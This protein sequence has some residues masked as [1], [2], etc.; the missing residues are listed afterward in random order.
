MKSKLL[1]LVGCL[2]FISVSAQDKNYINKYTSQKMQYGFI[3][4]K[5]QIYDQNYKANPD[6]K[7]L[8]SM[9]N[10]LNIQ[11]KANGFSY[12]TY[13]TEVKERTIE[14][15]FYKIRQKNVPQKDITYYFHRVD[16]ELLGANTNPKII[17]EE[18]SA[19]YM[20]YY[21]AVTPESGAT[22]VRTYRKVT[23]KDIYPNIDMVFEIKEDK[24]KHVEYTFILRPGADAKQI[25]LHYI[26]ANQTKLVNNKINIDV[27]HG[28]FTESIPASWIKETNN[29]L[30]ITYRVLEKDIYC[31][32]TPF[33]NPT[34]T[35]IIDPNPNLEWGTYYGGGGNEEGMSIFGDAD[36]N[37]FVTGYTM[38][39]NGI[40]TTGSHQETYSTADW[41]A[42][43]AK[44]NTNGVRQWGTYY[45]GETG[46][47]IGRRISCDTDGNI[48][49]TG[50]T[51]STTGIAT[52]GAH[53]ETYAGG[54]VYGIAGDAF[55]VKFNTNGIRQWG[56][57]YGGDGDDCGLG[58]SCDE[59]G[60]VFI[61][62]LTS[63]AA[64]IATSGAYQEVYAG[65]IAGSL[66]GDVFVVKFNTNGVCQWGTYYGG[67]GLDIG[68]GI[69]YDGNG[70]VFVTGNTNSTTGI[71]TSGAY[72]ET[73]AGGSGGSY[74]ADAFIAKFNTDG[75][76]QWGTYYG[77]S[78]CDVGLGIS[79][80]TTG[81]VFV[82]G[83]TASENGIVTSGAH[84]DT[85]AGGSY[86]GCD[87]FVA[88]F[89]TNGVCQWGTY[90]GGS[91]DDQGNGVCYDGDGNIFV[92]G[93]TG[94]ETGIATS[95][96]HQEINAGSDD[97]FIVKFNSDGVRQWGTYYGGSSGDYGVGIFY[98]AGDDILFV[99]GHTRSSTG[100]ATDGAHQETLEMGDDAFVAKFSI[101]EI[102]P[103]NASTILGDTIVC[104]GENSVIYTIPPI[105]NA[106][107]YVWMLP[108]G[109]TGT[110]DTNSIIVNYGEF[111]I[112]GNITV[113]G[114][115]ACGD[116]AESSLAITVNPLPVSAGTILGDTIICQGENSVIYTVSPIDNATSYVWMLPSG[117]TGTSDTNSI[118]V[119][120]GEFAISGNITVKG[121]NACGDGAESSLA[122]TVNP[123]P[124]SAGT[125]LGDTII[126]QGENS[127]IY[128][129]SPIDNATSYVWML[130][131]GVTGTSITDSITVDY[132][133]SA[134]SGN[135]TVM[136]TNVC[137]DGAV[138][139]LPITVNIK[140]PTPTIT[141]NGNILTSDAPEG[142]QWY[143]QG[144]L[145]NG[146]T[147]QDYYVSIDGDYYVIVTLNICSSDPSDTIAVKG[148]GTKGNIKAY[149][150]PV[151]DEL[152]IEIDNNNEI[153]NFDIINSRGNII[154]K[155]N[156]VDKVIVDISNFASGIYFIKLENG[157][158]FESKKIMIK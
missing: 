108:S 154:F 14:D 49:V 128:T 78:K 157:E 130:P 47:S 124:V 43:V 143:N 2:A 66:E 71:A 133:V 90:Y 21:N 153:I 112:S 156:L 60:Y 111:A 63:S 95:G 138:S 18:P 25:K 62:G 158:I 50:F 99:F 140:P 5:G 151:S 52:S 73:Y 33:Y 86:H 155:G 115:N 55:V 8:L 67:N 88:K 105:D 127:V 35:L 121:T 45:G 11:L 24:K 117:V 59:N 22:F 85:F 146:A 87:A 134:I 122:I 39:K 116:G 36:G 114:T 129:V 20:N 27:A 101:C 41:D 42:F 81:N 68:E 104:Q 79:C 76:Y 125:I 92:I 84:Q 120:Y 100:I 102:Y 123:L 32:E 89:N 91:M 69:S 9:H 40:A 107:S 28:S 6:V 77:G 83:Y 37:V 103:A 132:G 26:G 148:I 29:K 119:N 141:Q 74:E 61:T 15:S 4:N 152:I 56:T 23:Y 17:A 149:P 38:S 106:T 135:I 118:I 139:I 96:A 137:G 34:Q 51:K 80:D 113:K 13:K 147:N 58:I 72:Q 64:G 19:D 10:G 75:N 109:V 126:C 46:S 136:G 82:T 30:D 48:F 144:G 145:I 31:F 93:Y 110:S 131:S 16:V 98:N 65:G 12:D 7:Y 44:F 150:N 57:Y 3:E 53:Q 1:F 94:S 54:S 97:A 142:N 70:N